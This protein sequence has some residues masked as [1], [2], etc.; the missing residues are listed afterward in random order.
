MLFALIDGTTTGSSA[1]SSGGSD[2]S[3]A[4]TQSITL[5]IRP[6]EITR[7]APS[8][9]VVQQTFGGAWVDDWGTG[10]TQV[11]ISGTT[12]WRGVQGSDGIDLYIALKGMVWNSF[13]RKR[14]DARKNGQDPNLVVLKFVDALDSTVLSVIPTQFT[15][16]RSKSRPLLIQ[17]NISMIALAPTTY[18]PASSSGVS[19]LLSG[20]L[21]AAGLTSIASALSTIT[22]AISTAVSFVENDIIGPVTALLSTA[23]AVIGVVVSAVA[24]GVAVVSS[25]LSIATLVAQTGAQ[26][27][28][29]LA[30]ADGLSNSTMSS[31]VT[32]GGAFTNC[33]CL[34]S[35]TASSGYTYPDYSSI[36]GAS[37]CSSTAG[38]SPSSTYTIDGTNP[39]DD[40]VGTTAAPPVQISAAATNALQQI[41]LAD[42]VLS[43]LTKTQISS[44][45]TT[46]TAGITVTS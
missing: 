5:N 30:T 7:S 27:M 42:P 11:N 3:S 45:L 32:T 43:P 35:N 38:G 39:F 46:A 40:I 2:S 14:N 4:Q 37:N 28:Q 44:L 20:L 25:V 8:R 13:Y 17:Y 26:I 9:A 31:L 24:A 34:L 19:G 12:G 29:T 16:R 23:A 15:I 10:L 36:D 21:S 22:S 41:V 18:T 6:E 33:Y 1:S